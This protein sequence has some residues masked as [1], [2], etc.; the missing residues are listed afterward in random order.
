MWLSVF[1]FILNWFNKYLTPFLR[2]WW[3]FCSFLSRQELWKMEMVMIFFFQLIRLDL[4]ILKMRSFYFHFL[5]VQ[6]SCFSSTSIVWTK[7]LHDV[8]MWVRQQSSMHCV[9]MGA[10][11]CPCVSWWIL[12]LVVHQHIACDIKH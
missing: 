1:F 2:H 7:Y 11:L 8:F 9:G 12:I 6:N 4:P 3:C 10:C 5:E